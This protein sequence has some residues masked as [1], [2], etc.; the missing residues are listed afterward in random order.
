M[1]VE[2]LFKGLLEQPNGLAR[3]IVSKAG[4]DPSRLLEK[5]E[6]FIRQ[7]PRVT[8]DSG[9][10]G[11]LPPRPRDSHLPKRASQ[12][13]TASHFAQSKRLLY[14]AMYSKTVLVSDSNKDLLRNAAA[15]SGRQSP[16]G[17]ERDSDPACSEVPSVQ[18]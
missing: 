14:P 13:F 10:V 3:R 4:S 1:E 16:A 2:H 7:Q 12:P 5:T 9:Q 18:S 8:G 15:A 6:S 17:S 11:A